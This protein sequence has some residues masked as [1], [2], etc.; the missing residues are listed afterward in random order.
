MGP[1]RYCFSM[2]QSKNGLVVYRGRFVYGI[3]KSAG[4]KDGATRRSGGARLDRSQ[5][6]KLCFPKLKSAPAEIG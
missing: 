6:K 4:E 5:R 3:A 2:G 1:G